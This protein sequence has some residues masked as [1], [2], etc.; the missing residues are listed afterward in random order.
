IKIDAGVM[1]RKVDG[2]FVQ[3]A[4]RA[5]V[6]ERRCLTRKLSRTLRLTATALGFCPQPESDRH[7][8]EHL[9]RTI[10]ARRRAQERAPAG[11]VSAGIPQELRAAVVE[12]AER[13]TVVWDPAS[14]GRIVRE[15]ARLLE[16]RVERRVGSESR[17]PAEQDHLAVADRAWRADRL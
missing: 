8:I 5:L 1:K 15:L 9:R 16:E 4:R 6:E 7:H 10:S 3:E 12:H 14:G 13:C 11:G 2:R 17:C